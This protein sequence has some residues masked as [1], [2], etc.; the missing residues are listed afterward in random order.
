MVEEQPRGRFRPLYQK[1]QD[2]NSAW[3][4]YVLPFMTVAVIFCLGLLALAGL[5][6]WIEGLLRG[7]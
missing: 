3:K 4:D 7:N 1:G 5:V 6:F 2:P